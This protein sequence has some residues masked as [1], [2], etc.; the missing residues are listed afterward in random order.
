VTPA[1]WAELRRALFGYGPVTLVGL[2]T[3]LTLLWAPPRAPGD[4]L[5][6]TA[7]G[8]PG[9]TRA[10]AV[11]PAPLPPWDGAPACA[12]DPVGDAEVAADP[13]GDPG[14]TASAA[15]DVR[16]LCAVYGETL[17]I[18]VTVEGSVVL[19]AEVISGTDLQ[20]PLDVDPGEDGPE[21]RVRLHEG[22]GGVSAEVYDERTLA[23]EPAC[24]GVPTWSAHQLA[25]FDIPAACLGTPNRISIVQGW[26]DYYD[27]V[28]YSSSTDALP[29]LVVARLAT[30][31]TSKAPDLN[32]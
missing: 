24:R 1:A 8:E 25:L 31:S 12:T 4:A 15:V 18:V 16:R 14:A 6:A 29:E 27:P 5:P 13:A 7:G 32:P 23:V 30:W 19:P 2:L 21:F 3:L 9:P 26:L 22:D 10:G 17:Q 11:A 20:L 28:I